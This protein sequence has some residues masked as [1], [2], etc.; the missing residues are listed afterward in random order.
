MNLRKRNANEVVTKQCTVEIDGIG[1]RLDK[2]LGN[3]FMYHSRVEW[4]ENI[5]RGTVTVNGART[6]YKKRLKAG[7]VIVYQEL[8]REEPFVEKTIDILYDDGDLAIT[9]KSGNLPM[10]PSGRYYENTY[11][12][13]LKKHL[14]NAPKLINRIDR[15]TSGLVMFAR[16]EE[17]VAAIQDVIGTDVKKLY[18]AIVKGNVK[19]RRFTVMGNIGHVGHAWYRQLQGFA[20]EGKYSKT[21]FFRVASNGAYALLLCRIYTGRMHQIRVHLKSKGYFVV[22]DKVY[23]EHGPY[24]FK[25]FLEEG[26][27]D[28]LTEKTEMRRQAL[29]SYKINFVHPLTGKRIIVKA[30]LPSDMR[31]FLVEKGLAKPSKKEAN[32]Y[33]SSAR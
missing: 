9:A 8:F 22:G 4:V 3:R 24:A 16:T 12:M 1:C 13:I 25:D 7:D 19:E 28:A 5:E 18:L 14:Q 6:S 29:H 27:T 26:Q 17:T 30:P 20:A 2:Y 10:I 32:R 15:E 33:S 31:A 21:D 23:G 11:Y